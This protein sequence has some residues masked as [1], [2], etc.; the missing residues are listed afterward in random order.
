VSGY[1]RVTGTPV[2]IPSGGTGTAIAACGAGTKV[3]GGGFT[4]SGL[5]PSNGDFVPVSANY[6]SSD[7]QWTAS[8]A[9]WYSGNTVTLTAYAICVSG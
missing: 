4:A 8:V 9:T 5:D 6:P 7:T 3:V 2:V 1:V